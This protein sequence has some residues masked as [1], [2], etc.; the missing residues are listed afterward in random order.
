[1]LGLAALPSIIMFLGCLLLPE[2]PRWLIS[3]GLVDKARQVLVKI[4]GTEEVEQEFSEMKE[5]V[6]EETQLQQGLLF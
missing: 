2:S 5:V 4:R 3:H 6:R 1:M